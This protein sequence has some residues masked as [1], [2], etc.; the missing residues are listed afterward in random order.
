MKHDEI[1]LDFVKAQ[2][3]SRAPKI[4]ENALN[5][6]THRQLRK[7]VKSKNIIIKLPVKIE[8]L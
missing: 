5:N 3:V 6:L 7:I 4:I 2:L 8:Q 1:H